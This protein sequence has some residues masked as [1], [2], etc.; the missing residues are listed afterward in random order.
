M[1][2]ERFSDALLNRYALLTGLDHF[3]DLTDNVAHVLTLRCK[4][5]DSLS[6]RLHALHRGV[7]QLLHVNKLLFLRGVQV[8]RQVTAH[9]RLTNQARTEGLQRPHE[10]TV[11]VQA[12]HHAI[13]SV[14]VIVLNVTL[15]RVRQLERGTVHARENLLTLRT[16]HCLIHLQGQR[17]CVREGTTK[18]RLRNLDARVEATKEG[19]NPTASDDTVINVARA[20]VRHPS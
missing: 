13:L 17:Q 7:T 20:G 15:R 14:H 9:E 4:L 19:L 8:H 2:G 1:R 6:V 11:R 5:R 18:H 16:E 10:C 3:T 12:S